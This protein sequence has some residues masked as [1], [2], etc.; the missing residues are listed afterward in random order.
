[1]WQAFTMKMS[2]LL[3]T[4]EFALQL[5]VQ[6][7]TADFLPLLLWP[8][9]E[10][11]PSIWYCIHLGPPPFTNSQASIKDWRRKTR[12]RKILLHYTVKTTS[13]AFKQVQKQNLLAVLGQPVYSAS[14]FTPASVSK[15]SYTS[16]LKAYWEVFYELAAPLGWNHK[17]GCQRQQH[18]FNSA[19][20]TPW[21]T[22]L[23]QGWI[24]QSIVGCTESSNSVMILIS[25]A[26]RRESL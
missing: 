25:T 18:L 1:M 24:F 23:T 22:H 19:H 20:M 4:P 21:R 17:T 7:F 15:F 8:Q 14:Y 16:F 9:R 6:G 10:N 3:Q 13:L 2:V 11:T 12:N 5:T 26:L